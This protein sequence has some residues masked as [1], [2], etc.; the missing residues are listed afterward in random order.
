MNWGNIYS[1]DVS[2]AMS[3][4]VLPDV[5][6]SIKSAYGLDAVH[7]AKIGKCDMRAA[8]AFEVAFNGENKMTAV[9]MPS[10]EY[11][12][13]Y[14]GGIDRIDF[15]AETTLTWMQVEWAVAGIV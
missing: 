15:K 2:Q 13:A 7:E 14:E 10:G 5:K 11:G 9:K 6:G 8:A 12:V 1:V 3:G 4:D